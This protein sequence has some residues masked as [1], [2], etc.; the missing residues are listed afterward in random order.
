MR[1]KLFNCPEFQLCPHLA[2]EYL[3][4][5]YSRMD[6]MYLGYQHVRQTNNDPQ[7]KHIT[8]PRNHYGSPRY[9]Q[10]ILLYFLGIK[11]QANKLL[12]RLYVSLAEDAVAIM[13]RRGKPHF[14]LTM[15]ANPEWVIIKKLLQTGDITLQLFAPLTVH[16][17]NCIYVIFTQAKVPW[18][19]LTL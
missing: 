17:L 8:M 14:F 1:Q 6:D 5:A 10:I 12:Y 2:Q 19:V 16:V 9:V 13:R 11:V 3:L 7:T 4:D 15:T 18:I